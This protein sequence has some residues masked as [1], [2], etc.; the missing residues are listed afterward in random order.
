MPEH[1]QQL[2]HE[3]LVYDSDG[4]MVGVV[5]PY[6]EAGLAAGEPTV[7]VLTR[8]NWAIL[9][10][11][12]GPEAG[13][14]SYTDCDSFYTRPIAAIAAYD[15]TLRGHAAAGNPPVRVVGELPWGPTEREWREW[16]GYEALL[17]A[18]LSHHDASVLCTYDAR[19]L[20]DRLVDAALR[21]HPRTNDG[22][23]HA[24]HRYEPPEDVLRSL[25]MPP[26]EIDAPPALE[27]TDDVAVFR[28]QLGAALA[29]AGS[30]ERRALDMLL[31][32]TEIFTN[33]CRHGGGPTSLSAGITGG[34]FVCEVSDDGPGFDDPLAGYL[35]PGRT[36]GLGSGLWVARQLVSRL[37]L[38]Q[39]DPGLTAR[40]WL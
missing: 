36:P 24:N 37:E 33:A 38:I 6:L 18:S 3:A 9:R 28:E 17:N 5:A 35:P 39:R 15:A 31:A 2:R 1:D 27:I 12:L 11:A 21:T 30:P 7:A 20:P 34:W 16:T 29:T 32:G 25:A 26:V 10:E 8:I 40:L 14:V 19:N 23:H 4:E 13:K 22:D